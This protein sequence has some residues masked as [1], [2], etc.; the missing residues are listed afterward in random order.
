MIKTLAPLF[1]FEEKPQGNMSEVVR[2]ILAD[3]YGSPKHKEWLQK[4]EERYSIMR[5]EMML[6]KA[7]LEKQKHDS[8]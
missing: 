1:D 6:E 5:F 7:K 4:L 2:A 8:S 3:F